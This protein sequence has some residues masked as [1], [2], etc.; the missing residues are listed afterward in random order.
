M[1]LVVF[2]LFFFF[3]LV[4]GRLNYSIKNVATATTVT[5][6]CGRLRNVFSTAFEVDQKHAFQSAN[7]NVYDILC[8]CTKY[9]NVHIHTPVLTT[10]TW[11]FPVTVEHRNLRKVRYNFHP[12][13]RWLF[14][15]SFFSFCF[16]FRQTASRKMPTVSHAYM[17]C[18][19][20]ASHCCSLDEGLRY[21]KA[22]HRK[23]NLQPKD[24]HQNDEMTLGAA[25]SVRIV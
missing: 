22:S 12:R 24:E 11:Q 20:R 17:Y 25:R 7:K 9:K 6:V 23:F 15:A 14:A 18:I 19:L 5:T 1:K 10:E 8:T 4:L 16:F 3:F 21:A 13:R 2:C